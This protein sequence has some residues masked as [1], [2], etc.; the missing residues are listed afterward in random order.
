MATLVR[1]AVRRSL[2]VHLYLPLYTAAVV[3]ALSFLYCPLLKLL[4]DP[5]FVCRT[6][7]W[8]DNTLAAVVVLSY[9]YGMSHARNA[10][11][12]NAS[13]INRIVYWITMVVALLLFPIAVVAMMALLSALGLEF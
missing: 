13:R 12:K 3:G 8:L 2:F 10:L 4:R 6:P 11:P 9:A 1:R 7:E 5:K